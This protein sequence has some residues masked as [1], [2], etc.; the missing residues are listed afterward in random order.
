MLGFAPFQFIKNHCI[1]LN[2][3]SIAEGVPV[4]YLIL[5][6]SLLQEL[7]E[8]QERNFRFGNILG[9]QSAYDSV[10]TV[11]S[12]NPVEPPVIHEKFVYVFSCLLVWE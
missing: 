5:V 12:L 7:Q 4:K 2:Q 8:M 10:H 6:L 1:L 3:E 9:V 11:D